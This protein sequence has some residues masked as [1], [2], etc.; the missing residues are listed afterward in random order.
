[1]DIH[2]AQQSDRDLLVRVSYGGG[3]GP[4]RFVVMPSTD[5]GSRGVRLIAGTPHETLKVM[6]LGTR[7]DRCE[8]LF[9]V[10][11]LLDMDFLRKKYQGTDW[12]TVL[13]NIED[14]PQ[15]ITYHL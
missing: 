13:L 7:R 9:F 6:H 3:C 11:A 12:K 1:M 2:S 14:G 8:K 10:D 15:N 5:C 4:H